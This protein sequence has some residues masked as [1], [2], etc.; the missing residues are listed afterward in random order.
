MG[1]QKS[2]PHRPEKHLSLVLL[3]MSLVILA[4][5]VRMRAAT[6]YPNE[7]SNLHVENIA[8]TSVDVVWDTVHPSTSQALLCRDMNYQPEIRV[9]WT[10]SVAATG[11][12]STGGGSTGGGPASGAA[13]SVLKVSVPLTSGVSGAGPMPAPPPGGNGGGWQRQ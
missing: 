13:T 5:P 10:V 3:C 1:L 12:G 9:P 6:G 2:C 4:G 11:G 8:Q 7:I